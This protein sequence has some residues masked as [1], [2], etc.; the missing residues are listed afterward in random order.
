MAD[1]SGR[2][3]FGWSPPAR[4]PTTRPQRVIDRIFPATG[5][6][7]A[8]YIVAVVA[9]LGTAPHLSIRAGLA[10][11]GLAAF[12]AGSWCAVNFWR[13]GH[14]HCLID[15]SGWLV[16]AA[17]AF[18]GAGLGRSII[19]GSE[20]AVFLGVLVAALIFEFVWSQARGTNAIV[21]RD[22]PSS[23]SRAAS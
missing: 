21:R 4:P 23:R 3:L 15:G 20:E 11:D 22:Q 8:L 9:L 1:D 16:L 12:A 5:A 17:L 2:A 13:C 7:C 14:A 18:V 6:G 19:G 10:A